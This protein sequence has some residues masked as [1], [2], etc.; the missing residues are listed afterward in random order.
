MNRNRKERKSCRKMIGIVSHWPNKQRQTTVDWDWKRANI[1]LGL[2]WNHYNGPDTPHHCWKTVHRFS[3][4]I[5]CSSELNLYI[6]LG[7]DWNNTRH[8]TLANIYTWL[9]KIFPEKKTVEV[10]IYFYKVLSNKTSRILKNYNSFLDIHIK[11]KTSVTVL[12][13]K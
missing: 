12:G 4:T 10:S 3:Y 11:T 13:N 1:C 8:C 6:T 2:R 9:N 7:I 5:G